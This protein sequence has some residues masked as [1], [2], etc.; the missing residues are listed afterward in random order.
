MDAP[1]RLT[2]VKA[3]RETSNRRYSGAGYFRSFYVTLRSPFKSLTKAAMDV[4]ELLDFIENDD[5]DDLT[6]C[7]DYMAGAGQKLKEVAEKMRDQHCRISSPLAKDFEEC[8]GMLLI[9]MSI[10]RL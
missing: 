7:E 2:P 5:T 8:C 4:N 9:D 1:L 3:L 6:A 10:S